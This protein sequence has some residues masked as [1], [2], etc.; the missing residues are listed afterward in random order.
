[1]GTSL[2]YAILSTLSYFQVFEYPLTKGEI[3]KYL[4]IKCNVSELD[5][6]LDDLIQWKVVFRFDEFYCLKNDMKYVYRRIQGNTLGQEKLKKAMVV[7]R[8]LGLFP[9]VDAVCVSGSLSKD[10]ASKDSDLDF[11]IITAP[12]RLWTARNLMHFFRKLTFVVNAQRLFCM[13]YYISA[14]QLEIVPQ[15]IYTAIELLSLKPGYTHKGWREMNEVN[16]EWV[17]EYLPNAD[18]RNKP[19]KKH[20]KNIL[21]K[22]LESIINLIGGDRVEQF[23][24]RTTMKRWARKWEKMGYDVEQCMRSADYDFNTPVNYPENLPQIILE[25]HEHIYREVKM[26]L[27]NVTLGLAPEVCYN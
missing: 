20:K 12:N 6:V 2:H 19:H 8:F 9:F 11:F 24:F 15:D 21:T 25:K 7:S 4:S 23:F 13:N 26:K 16:N 18:L 10:F 14:A 22:A 1:M 27:L 5:N 3:W 17:A